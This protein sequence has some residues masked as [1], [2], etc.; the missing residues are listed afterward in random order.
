MV[1]QACVVCKCDYDNIRMISFGVGA[2]ELLVVVFPLL[3]ILRERLIEVFTDL[4]GYTKVTVECTYASEG[5]K[6]K[7]IFRL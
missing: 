1:R 7:K 2:T 6:N 5:F 4:Y 3:D